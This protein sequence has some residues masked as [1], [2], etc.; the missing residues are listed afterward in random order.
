[1]KFYSKMPFGSNGFFVPKEAVDNIHLCTANQLRVLLLALNAKSGIHSEEIARKLD[2]SQEDAED[3][4][5]YWVK[6]NILAI[7][8]ESPKKTENDLS[9]FLLECQRIWGKPFSLSEQETIASLLKENHIP[10]EILQRELEFCTEKDKANI[11][12]F[13]NIAQSFSDKG[14]DSLDKCE[15]MIQKIEENEKAVLKAKE[16][17]SIGERDLTIKEKEYA[18]KWAKFGFPDDLFRLADKRCFDNTGKISFTYIDKI[19]T[20]WKQNGIDTVAKAEAKPKKEEKQSSSPSF[21]I[22]EIERRMRMEDGV[23]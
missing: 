1:M 16:I 17:F 8:N 23:I 12:Y 4:L 18:V 6:R 9:S 22:A 19:L 21:D 3:L 14:I 2:I 15:N 10:E 5:T 20:E 13:R 11:R 7:E